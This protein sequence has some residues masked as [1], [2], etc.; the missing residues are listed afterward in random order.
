MQIHW[1]DKWLQFE[2]LGNTV[3]LQGLQ[4]KATWGSPISLTQLQAMLKQDS[5]LYMLELNAIQEEHNTEDTI[6][7]EIQT[8]INKYQS[9]FQPIP[10]FHPREKRI[11]LFHYF[12]ELNLFG[13]GLIGTTLF[14]R[15]K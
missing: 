8:L 9:I 2:Y 11:I 6:P 14:R 7:A 10:T 3:L 15:T 5:V 4:S 1:A 12:L 13:L